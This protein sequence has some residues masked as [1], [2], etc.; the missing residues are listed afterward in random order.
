MVKAMSL[1]T[2]RMKCQVWNGLF[3]A[4]QSYGLWNK[5]VPEAGSPSFDAFK[6][7][8][9]V[10]TVCYWSGG[11]RLWPPSGEIS[12]SGSDAASQDSLHSASCRRCKVHLGVSLQSPWSVQHEEPLSC[13][14]SDDDVSGQSSVISPLPAP[15]AFLWQLSGWW[16]SYHQQIFNSRGL[17]VLGGTLYCPETLFFLLLNCWKTLA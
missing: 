11:E 10:G 17:L 9:A 13:F 12:C 6:W 8:A 1:K 14:F 15:P 4:Q 7:T 3:S 16:R 5:T 2:K